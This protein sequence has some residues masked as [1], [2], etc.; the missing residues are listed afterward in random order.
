MLRDKKFIARPSE[1]VDVNTFFA[2]GLSIFTLGC[3][4]GFAYY[5]RTEKFIYSFRKDPKPMFL[6]LRALGI[7][8]I[9]SFGFFG[10]S[11]I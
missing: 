1:K 4:G 5:S 8:S 6:A 7:A 3:F 2:A 11:K 10:A 9:I